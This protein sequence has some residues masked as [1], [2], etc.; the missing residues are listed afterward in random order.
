MA[1]PQSVIHINYK[2]QNGLFNP[3][4]VWGELR[5]VAEVDK[6]SWTTVHGLEGK[7][8]DTAISIATRFDLMKVATDELN[9]SLKALYSFLPP[10][11][12]RIPESNDGVVGGEDI[13]AARDRVL[14]HTDSV[15]FEF[16]SYL[17]LVAKFVYGILEGVQKA[18][19]S[20]Q[21]LSSGKTVLLLKPKGGLVTHN[22]LLFL[23]DQHTQ[24]G[25]IP[26]PSADWFTF[27]SGDRNLFT[28]GGAP[29]C[30]IEE[31]T[32]VNRPFEVLIMRKNILDFKTAATNDYFRISEFQDVVQ[33][34]TGL[35]KIA[36][37]YVRQKI[38]EGMR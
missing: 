11:V 8:S 21:T 10:I 9:I 3:A 20:E 1:A 2:P 37:S 23:F 33:G 30:A 13:T 34:V 28:H 36:E 4:L 35:S 31:R 32:D 29:Y 7:F 22:F 27:L 5:K 14:L 12:P 38:S 25:N 19:A 6:L 15:F 26:R 17:E 16:R 24:A 18:P